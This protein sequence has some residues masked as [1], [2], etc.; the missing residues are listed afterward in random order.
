MFTSLYLNT[1][2]WEWFTLL[3]W[4]M[5]RL[6]FFKFR[7]KLEWWT[8]YSFVEYDSVDSYRLEICSLY[9]SHTKHK[10][11]I[12]LIHQTVNTDEMQIFLKWRLNLISHTF[13][14]FFMKRLQSLII[15]FQRKS[16]KLAP[17]YQ[18]GET[19]EF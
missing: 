17:V 14:Y 11:A 15:I 7:K 8:R 1:I 13:A 6:F 18:K 5:Y 3:R 10:T 16:I 2:K 4:C 12:N 9:L 19:V